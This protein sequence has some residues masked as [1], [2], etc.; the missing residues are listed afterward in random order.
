VVS[1]TLSLALIVKGDLAERDTGNL[2]IQKLTIAQQ[3]P[4]KIGERESIDIAIN[5]LD[6]ST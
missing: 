1:T 5:Y 6:Q 4:A 3:T 2:G